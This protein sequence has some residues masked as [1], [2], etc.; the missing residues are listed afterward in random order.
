M[1]V[2][3]GS[4]GLDGGARGELQ[5]ALLVDPMAASDVIGLQQVGEDIPE[6]DGPFG[7]SRPPTVSRW[8]EPGSSD[9]MATHRALVERAEQAGWQERSEL[10]R[11]GVW[12]GLKPGPDGETTMKIVIELENDDHAGDL[13]RVT[14]AYL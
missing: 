14:L 4:C 11:Q 5:D 6:S 1:S 7:M 3:L 8:F 13:V 10:T 12:S 9:P 2:V